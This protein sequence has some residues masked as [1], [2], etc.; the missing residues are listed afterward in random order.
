MKY[1]KGIVL[2]ALMA[3]VTG[4]GP[5]REYSHYDMA[6]YHLKQ[7][8]VDQALDEF[9]MSLAADPADPTVHE[10]LADVYYNK[11]F[12]EQ[13]IK[14]WETAM[15]LSFEDPEK[16]APGPDGKR[17]S[18]AW[19]NDGFQARKRAS[20][21]LQMALNARAED[22]YRKKNTTAAIAD[23]KRV[24]ALNNRNLEAWKGMAITFRKTKQYQGAYDAYREVLNLDPKYEKGYKY[25]GYMAFALKKLDEAEKAFNRYIGMVPEDP[26]GFNNMGTVLAQQKRYG[27]AVAMYD[28]ALDLKPNMVSSLNGRATAYY[29]KKDYDKARADWKMVLDLEPENTVAKENIRTLVRMGY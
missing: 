26:L 5:S 13:G 16:Y 11:G 20:E 28:K 4:C 14:H 1:A 7:K 27:L 22:H 12:K 6:L 19:I 18:T 21:K 3:A 15:E 25:L 10:A 23:W 9:K 24:V 29:Y 8:K 17:R 2:A